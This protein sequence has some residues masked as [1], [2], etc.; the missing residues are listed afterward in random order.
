MWRVLTC[1]YMCMCVWCAD[2][3]MCVWGADVWIFVWCADL[4]M[5]EA[6]PPMHTPFSCCVCKHTVASPMVLNA[7]KAR[8]MVGVGKPTPEGERERERER[9]GARDLD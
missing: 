1:M 4:C 5:C 8:R 9:E 3:C 6:P 7:T 2:L